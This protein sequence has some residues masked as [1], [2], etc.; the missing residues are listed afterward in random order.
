[1]ARLGWKRGR[2]DRVDRVERP[3]S[4]VT[5]EHFLHAASEKIE[6]V[7]RL[8]NSPDHSARKIPAL[9]CDSAGQTRKNGRL[10]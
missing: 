3:E 9:L 10:R 5:E 8:E 6:R 4:A 7:G 2:A 1:M